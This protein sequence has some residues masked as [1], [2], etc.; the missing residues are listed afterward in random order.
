MAKKKQRPPSGYTPDQVKEIQDFFKSNDFTAMMSVDHKPDFS[1]N[2]AELYK[3]S[4]YIFS[5]YWLKNLQGLGINRM[6]KNFTRDYPVKLLQ[7]ADADHFIEQIVEICS[8]PE[9]FDKVFMEF[10]DMYEG[11]IDAGIDAY[12]K[13]FGRKRDEIT[14]EEFEFVLGKIVEVLNE[15]FIKVL[16]LGQQVPEVY[17]ISAQIRTHED[18]NKSLPGNYDMINFHNKWTHCKT[19]LGAPL[20]FSELSEEEMTGLEGARSFFESADAHTQKEYEEIRDAFANTL[21]ST[22]REI[23]YMRE[24]GYTHAEIAQRLGYKTHSAVT[25]RLRS[26]REKYDEFCGNVEAMQK[27]KE[28]K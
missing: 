11:Q 2:K 7:N 22:D 13:N 21:N 4:K 25:K 23:Y 28:K 10:Y 20:L 12:C 9:Q 16:M 27:E 6:M 3:K 17:D 5:Q 14:Q 8:D 1:G 26:M 18:F 19:K 15:E 24:K